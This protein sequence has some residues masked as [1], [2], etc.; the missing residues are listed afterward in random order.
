MVRSILLSAGLAL[1]LSAVAHA[2]FTPAPLA[3]VDNA[4]VRVAQA[5]PPGSLQ[6]P[7]GRCAPLAVNGRCPAGYHIGALGRRCWPN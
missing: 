3:T 1:S 4:I 5:C 7:L 6:G 2:S